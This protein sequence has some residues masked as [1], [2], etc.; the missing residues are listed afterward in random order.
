MIVQLIS[1]QNNQLTVEDTEGKIQVYQVD[2]SI[3]KELEQELNLAQKESE[4]VSI[5]EQVLQG[6]R[7]GNGV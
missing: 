6:M 2:V 7:W 1:V 5:D 3:A 4:E